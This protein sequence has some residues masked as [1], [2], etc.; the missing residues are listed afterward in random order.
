MRNLLRLVFLR[1]N[2]IFVTS[3]LGNTAR[4]VESA[5]ATLDLGAD[6]LSVVQKPKNVAAFEI[7]LPMESGKTRIFKAWRVQHN[8]ARGP[9][10]GGIRFHPD[11]NLDEVSALASL[12]TWKTALVGVPY[13][14]AKGAVTVNPKALSAKELED[15]S[16]SYIRH[17]RDVIGPKKDIPAPDVGTTPQIMA[18]MV[19]EYSKLVGYFEPNAFTGKPLEIG[20]SFG[21][22][23]ATGFGGAVILREFLKIR[24]PKHKAQNPKPSVA[25]QGFGAV[26]STIAQLLFGDGYRVAALSDSRGA[27]VDAEGIDVE[28]IIRAQGEKRKAGTRP[29]SLEEAGG[30]KYKVMS[31]EELL[32]LDVDIL[33]P[34]ALENVITGENAGR[35]RARVILEMA[36]GPVTPEAEEVLAKAGVEVIPDI[37][38]NAGGVVGSYF[39]WVQGLQRFYW[40]EDEVNGKIERILVNAMSAVERESAKGGSWREAAYRLA[41]GRVAEAMRLRGW[42]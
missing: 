21:R 27:I 12:M 7:P 31:N 29:V 28:G 1:G 38:A 30:G 9:Y 19:D 4:Y 10:K 16:R 2:K 25:I 33:I 14:G 26:G 17:L 42:V 11:S 22:D 5:A 15:V 35:I 32:E 18:W 8:D 39:E 41:V 3:F 36:N 24:N 37:L 20:G 34:A 6:V 23:T 40:E 13:G